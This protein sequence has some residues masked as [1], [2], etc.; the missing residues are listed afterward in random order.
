MARF[1]GRRSG[2]VRIVGQRSRKV[3][4]PLLNAL[5]SIPHNQRVILLAH[6]SDSTRDHLYEAIARVLRSERVPFAKRLFLKS[7]LAPYRHQL[8]Y[9]ANERASPVRKRRAL[10]QIG[11]GPMKHIL[12]T[13]IPLMLNLFPKARK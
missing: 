9:L 8:R 12:G 10:A 6:L 1:I 13:A 5:R 11:G 4:L 7:K 3:I 2:K